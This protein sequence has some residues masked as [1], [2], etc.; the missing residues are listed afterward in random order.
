MDCSK[1]ESPESI[2]AH[3]F[4]GEKVD[5][6]EKYTAMVDQKMQNTFAEIIVI[7]KKKNQK[8]QW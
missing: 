4:H 2:L 3:L 5:T 6:Y 1:E 7:D 8:I